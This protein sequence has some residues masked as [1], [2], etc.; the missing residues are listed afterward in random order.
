MI[1]LDKIKD[2]DSKPRYSDLE[3]SVLN[4]FEK[5]EIKKRVV[6]DVKKYGDEIK[7][8]FKVGDKQDFMN[9]GLTVDF[10]AKKTT[11]IAESMLEAKLDELSKS[12]PEVK[13]CFV[14]TRTVDQEKVADLMA[15]GILDAALLED[16]TVTDVTGALYV[17]KIK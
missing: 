13:E 9:V 12:I 4:Y 11:K 6:K 14:T 17:S 15:K 5:N 10:R 8:S 7:A 2:I 1:T 16:C 3:F